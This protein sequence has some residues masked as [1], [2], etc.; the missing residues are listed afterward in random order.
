MTDDCEFVLPSDTG[1]SRCVDANIPFADLPRQFVREIRT[2]GE[3]NTT[4]M[5]ACYDQEL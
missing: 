2:A 4:R 1:P 3:P 5:G